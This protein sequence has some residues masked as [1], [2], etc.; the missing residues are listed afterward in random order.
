MYHTVDKVQLI[1]Y[2]YDA[3]SISCIYLGFLY[4]DD[5]IA[6]GHS[7]KVMTLHPM[8]GLYTS[9]TAFFLCVCVCVCVC[10]CFSIIIST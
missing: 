8:V 1:S 2:L 4:L 5:I 10:V 7:H 6:Q 9:V 3:M